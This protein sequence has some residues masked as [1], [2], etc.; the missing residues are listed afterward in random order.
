[1]C[2]AVPKIG[3][4]VGI[5]GTNPS[6]LRDERSL[7]RGERP[8]STVRLRPRHCTARRVVRLLAFIEAL[9]VTGPLRNLLQFAPHVDLEIATYRRRSLGE[10]HDAGIAAMSAAARNAG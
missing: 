7:W 5:E 10:R 3:T 2:R 8:F 4:A 9:G 1:M 6:R